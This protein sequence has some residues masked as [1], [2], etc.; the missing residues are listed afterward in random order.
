MI[1]R[2]TLEDIEAL[3]HLFDAY[4]VFY[5]KPTD[6]NG[7]ANF[8]R[9]RMERNE[10]V[11]FV[12]A[13]EEGRIYGF[14]QLYLLFSSTRMKKLWLLNDLFVHPDE[15][16]QGIAKDLI[17]AC[18]TLCL[19]TAACSLILETAKSNDIGNKLYPAVGF[20]LDVEHNYYSW[21]N[22]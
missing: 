16:Q 21:D 20:S 6:L 2:A 22:E 3:A 15:R 4:R 11:I 5:K 17:E 14:V 9:E 1:R 10:S 18:K 13:N 12:S 19:E 7:A 8:L